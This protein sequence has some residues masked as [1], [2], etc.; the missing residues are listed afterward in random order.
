MNYTKYEVWHDEK[1]NDGFYHG[2]LFV[3][4]NK[5]SEIIDYLKVIRK[6]YNYT[7][8]QTI[9]YCQSIKKPKLLKLISNHISL[10][11]HISQSNCKDKTDIFNLSGA[12]KHNK[13]Y[14][15]YLTIIG[16]FDCKFGLLKIDENLKCFNHCD[17]SKKVEVT[18]RFI[19]KSCCHSMFNELNPILISKLYFDGQ[20]HHKNGYDLKNLIKGDLRD[21]VTIKQGNIID[22]RTRKERDSE[23]GMM[24]DFVDNIIGAFHSLINGNNN[25]NHITLP[26]ADIYKNIKDD[27]LFKNKNSR[28]YKSITCSKCDVINDEIKFP[29]LFQNENQLK[30]L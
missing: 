13:N 11:S 4:I 12:N 21:Y 25:N 22:A 14:E 24:I 1:K 26:I 9:K 29:N 10:F 23:S 17:Y 3:P 15:P 2:I 30:L 27:L 20:E 18:Y 7:D 28:W 5:K 19:F 8:S 6:K 16:N